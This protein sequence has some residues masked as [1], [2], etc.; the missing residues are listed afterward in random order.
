VRTGAPS[1]DPAGAPELP[2]GWRIVRTSGPLGFVTRMAVLDPEGQEYE[3]TSRRHR[4][5]LGLTA[6]AAGRSSVQRTRPSRM[7]WWLAGLFGTG[8]VAFALGSLPLFFGR[9][10]QAVLGRTF[11]VGSLFFTAA[12]ILQFH[13]TLTTSRHITGTAPRR[14]RWIFHRVQ[15]RIDWWAALIQLIGTIAFN[16][17]TFAATRTLDAS[18][19]ERLIWAPDVVGSGCFLVASWLA[20]AEVN[21]GALPRSDRSVGWRIAAVNLLG[22]IAFGAAAVAARYVPT[23]GEPAD[24]ALVNIGTCAGAVCFLIGA[25]LLPVESSRDAALQTVR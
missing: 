19:D 14:R 21:R 11:F 24:I 10:D 9:V 12:G 6:A 17:S 13:E 2:A 4:K 7:S 15:H 18:Q 5:R 16:V 20:Y 3:W 1:R 25:V 22:S 23:S 8:S